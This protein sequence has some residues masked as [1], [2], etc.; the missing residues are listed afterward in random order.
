[1]RD[2]WSIVL[3]SSIRAACI[4]AL[5]VSL[6]FRGTFLSPANSVAGT[7]SPLSNSAQP[8][9]A[10]QANARNREGFRPAFQAGERDIHGSQLGGT[11][12]INLVAFQEKLYAGTGYWEDPDSRSG[13]QIM[14]LDSAGGRWRQEYAF[15]EKLPERCLPLW[16]ID[17][18]PSNHVYNGCEWTNASDAILLADRRIGGA[19]RL[20]WWRSG[21]GRGVRSR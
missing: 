10:A 1:M 20:A 9:P 2:A 7:S 3:I 19:R 18:T 6:L 5:F 8:A 17:G 13:P 11:E 14:V 12:L 4:V 15:S 21:A 16:K